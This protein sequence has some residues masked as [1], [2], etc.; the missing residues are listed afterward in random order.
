MSTLVRRFLKNPF[1]MKSQQ[2]AQPSCPCRSVAISALR[3]LQ[4]NAQR[5]VWRTELQVSY[6]RWKYGPVLPGQKPHSLP[7]PL[8]VSLTSYPPRFAI[9]PLT[10]KCLLSQSVRPDIVALWIAEKD[11]TDLTPEIL[12]LRDHGLKINF[13]RDLRSFT[14]I[15]PALMKY[16]GYFIM[17][18]DDDVYYNRNC[19]EDIVSEYH[20]DDKEIL[21]HCAHKIKLDSAGF[22]LRYSDWG[23][24]TRSK[25]ASPSIFPLG[26]GG[27]LYPPGVFDDRVLDEAMFSSLCPTADDV[28]LYWMFR[29]NGAVAKCLSGRHGIAPWPGSQDVAL[30]RENT[31]GNSLNDQYIAS[32]I[33]RFGPVWGSRAIPE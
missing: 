25:D 6:Y 19:L 27:V 15:I 5:R 30:W 16:R 32:M 4:R 20:G 17:T 13:C 23:R 11:K 21:C 24:E 8:V 9:L 7:R 26:V 28:W 2:T 3:L 33:A 12:S 1:P 10:L 22:P 14:K 31:Q 18:A 29:L